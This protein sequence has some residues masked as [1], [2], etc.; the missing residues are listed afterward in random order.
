MTKQYVAHVLGLVKPYWPVANLIPLGEGMA[1]ECTEEKFAE[2][3]EEV[4]PIAEKVIK[5]LE[6]E[7]DPES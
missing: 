3:L 6:Q 4:N 1:A 5:S 7:A 2:Y